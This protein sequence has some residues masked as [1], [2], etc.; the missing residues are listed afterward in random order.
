MNGEPADTA[1]AQGYITKRSTG[2]EVRQAVITTYGDGS[3]IESRMARHLLRHHSSVA[4]GD[5]TG[6]RPV[7][8]DRE[9][10]ILKLVADGYTDNEIGRELYIS[11]RTV[12]NHLTRIREKTGL[13]RRSELARW[14]VE[15]AVV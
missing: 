1:G 13:R 8:S 14:A 4:A 10:S 11:P 5:L 9:Q 3:V 15:H 7:L 12:Q 2:E 6:V